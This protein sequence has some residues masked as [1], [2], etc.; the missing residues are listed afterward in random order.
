MES[1]NINKR[2]F[3]AEGERIAVKDLMRKGYRILATNYRVGRLGEIDIIARQGEYICF[4]EVK[5]RSNTFFGMPAEAVTRKKQE[6]IRKIASVYINQFK[7]HNC[8][9]RFDIVEILGSK[10]KGEFEAKEINV[11]QNAF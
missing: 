6:N 2:S 1:N 4:V 7:L 8:N 9:V 11:L 3:G 5:T 10:R